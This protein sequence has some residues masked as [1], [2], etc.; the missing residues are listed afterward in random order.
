[1][2]DK[3]LIHPCFDQLDRESSHNHGFESLKKLHIINSLGGTASST[4]GKL[5]GFVC[6]LASS[7]LI[8]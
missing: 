3:M 4:V 2:W 6:L 8:K 1:M 5:S 7:C